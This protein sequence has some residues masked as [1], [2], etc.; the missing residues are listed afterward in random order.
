[1]KLELTEQEMFL[2]REILTSTKR[3]YETYFENYEKAT[4]VNRLTMDEKVDHLK[5]RYNV[6]QDVLSKL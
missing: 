5:D 6:I 3:T 1:M 2:V 4:G